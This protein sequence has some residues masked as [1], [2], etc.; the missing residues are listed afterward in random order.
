MDNRN[1]SKRSFLKVIAALIII[2]VAIVLLEYGA[3]W[4]ITNFSEPLTFLISIISIILSLLA[5][6]YAYIRT[7]KVKIYYEDNSD[8]VVRSEEI[9]WMRIRAVCLNGL[10]D[11][12][13]KE[14]RLKLL[15]VERLGKGGTWE[16]LSPI[17][18]FYLRYAIDTNS[19]Q[20][21]FKDDLN[22][23]ESQLFNLA[24]TKKG[25]S[26]NE[27]LLCPG[28]LNQG[29]VAGWK[30]SEW[31]KAGNFRYTIGIYGS[32]VKSYE[33]EIE[34]EL[35]KE[36]NVRFTNS[37]K[38]LEKD[39]PTSENRQL[40]PKMSS[41]A[42]YALAFLGDVNILVSI[43]TILFGLYYQIHHY[44]G[45]IAELV[46]VIELSLG[47]ILFSA[48]TN[49]GFA[50]YASFVNSRR[51]A[52][53]RNWLKHP[54]STYVFMLLIGSIGISVG[55]SNIS[56]G[57]EHFEYTKPEIETLVLTVFLS[58]A[59]MGLGFYTSGS[60]K[61]DNSDAN[62]VIGFSLKEVVLVVG[63]TI[64]LFSLI[65]YVVK[66]LYG[67]V[68]FVTILA[69]LISIYLSS[70]TLSREVKS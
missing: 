28:I 42:K 17:N 10:F 16:K 8:F 37:V 64:S 38:Q 51:I 25:T 63:I 47:I 33:K 39:K 53:K 7:A 24:T 45:W 54:S 35:T 12:P 66:V 13:A 65:L 68:F 43:L 15:N 59:T 56:V 11:K 23:G 4:N 9:V 2:L 44:F 29:N 26:N 34:I 5:F 3:S 52:Q 21:V 61:S 27:I 58:I 19:E 1:I 67:P 49:K 69:L 36:H 18:N 6:F 60:R 48:S 32:N 70:D 20:F 40:N 31:F 46:I 41:N 14:L 22:K 50:A 55:L 62:S 57:I 30:P